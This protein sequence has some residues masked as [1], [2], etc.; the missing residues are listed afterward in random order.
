[1]FCRGRSRHSPHPPNHTPPP[2]T[3]KQTRP[4][5]HD[6]AAPGGRGGL[7]APRTTTPHTDTPGSPPGRGGKG[8][9]GRKLP[10]EERLVERLYRQAKGERWRA[11][12]ARFAQALESSAERAFAGRSPDS[13]ELE[14]Y[15]ASL[16]L[17]DLAL[18][19][20][21]AAGDEEAWEHF[22]LEQRP[23]LYRAADALD[24]SGGRP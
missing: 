24:P 14:R 8:A 6:P 1:M 12:R 2:P 11:P 20:A 5:H 16:H 4:Q 15:L 3:H 23:L 17:E 19:C 18:A 7:G 21:C 9:A 22:V 13:R 10:I